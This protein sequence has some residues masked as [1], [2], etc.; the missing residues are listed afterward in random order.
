MSNVDDAAQT[1]VRNLE[2]KTGKSLDQWVE[3]VNASGLTKN[4]E[5]IDFLK[6][7]YGLTYGYANMIAMTAAQSSHRAAGG[8][9]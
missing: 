9:R 8:V 1:M 5:I 2:L 6:S 3:I 4:R 7:E